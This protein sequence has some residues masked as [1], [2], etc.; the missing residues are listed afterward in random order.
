ME[1]GGKGEAIDMWLQVR[2]EYLAQ[3]CLFCLENLLMLGP[4]LNTCL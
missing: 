1:T 4:L 3:T 2:R